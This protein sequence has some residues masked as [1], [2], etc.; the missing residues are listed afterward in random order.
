MNNSKIRRSSDCSQHNKS[1]RGRNFSL[2]RCVGSTVGS[3][4]ANTLKC[5]QK[6]EAE[7][8][9]TEQHLH[10]APIEQTLKQLG[11]VTLWPR[12]DGRP[13]QTRPWRS[14]CSLQQRPAAPWAGWT[15]AVSSPGAC[16]DTGRASQPSEVV[17]VWAEGPRRAGNTS[18]LSPGHGALAAGR[19]CLAL[20]FNAASILHDLPSPFPAHADTSSLNLRLASPQDTHG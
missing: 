1:L 18:G 5:H 19:R 3:T 8:R 12:R 7:T 4:S 14:P 17:A 13:G 11:T 6:H 16:R 2:F 9:I 20:R 10:R 15:T